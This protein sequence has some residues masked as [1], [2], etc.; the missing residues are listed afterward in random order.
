VTDL[1]LR[2]FAIGFAMAW[3]ILRPLILGFTLSAV[4]EAVVSHR[5]MARLLDNLASSARKR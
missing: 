3:E 4:I 1:L 5:Q 2:A